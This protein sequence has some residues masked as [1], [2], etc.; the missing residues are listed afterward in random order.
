MSLP[1]LVK[2]ETRTMDRRCVLPVADFATFLRRCGGR[3]VDEFEAACL[4]HLFRYSP[5]C[6]LLGSETH[7]GIIN[8]EYTRTAYGLACAMLFVDPIGSPAQEFHIDVKECDRDAVWNLLVPLRVM[9]EPKMAASMFSS[10]G[11]R[12]AH[13]GEATMWDAGWDHQ[14]LGNSTAHDCFFL[15]LLF[16]PFW[17]LVPDVDSQM[18]HF[19]DRRLQCHIHDAIAASKKSTAWE[20]LRR[21]QTS[22]EQEYNRDA[23]GHVHRL[24]G[25]DSPLRPWCERMRALRSTE[26]RA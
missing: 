7:D 5:D 19:D 11:G 9:D 3:T 2:I 25:D 6:V 24:Y 14:G 16:I 22:V 20:Y 18:W 26:A 10:S 23:R 4:D 12:V 13:A 1:R 21:V 15:H 17:L 8:R